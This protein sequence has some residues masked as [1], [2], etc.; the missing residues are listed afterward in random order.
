MVRSITAQPTLFQLRACDGDIVIDE[1][2]SI[3]PAKSAAACSVLSS[4]GSGS[5]S[6]KARISSAP[7]PSRPSRRSWCLCV[8]VAAIS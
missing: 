4:S 5:L 2:A 6:T 3:S 8:K 1:T 7:A